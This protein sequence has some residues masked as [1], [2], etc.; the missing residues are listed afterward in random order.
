MLGLSERQ[1]RVVAPYIGGGFG[2]KIMMF[3][4]EES[5]LPWAAM[6]LN[7]PI[8]W[9]E[10]RLEHFVATTHERC[11]IHDAEIELTT[12]G[13]ILGITDTIL[14]DTR[15]YNPYALND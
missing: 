7:R 5:L 6:K 3:Y 2:P 11:Q 9:I 12:D 13:D 10:D 4:P 15:A 1:V 8:K 14:H